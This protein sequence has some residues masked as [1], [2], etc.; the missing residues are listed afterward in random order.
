M[1][2]YGVLCKISCNLGISISSLF[3][4]PLLTTS[5]QTLNTETLHIPIRRLTSEF[6]FLVKETSHPYADRLPTARAFFCSSMD[7][8]RYSGLHLSTTYPPPPL[9]RYTKSP[10][11]GKCNRKICPKPLISALGSHFLL[12]HCTI[13]IHAPCSV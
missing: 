3:L 12:Y 11:P 5:N 8:R 6:P 10:K 13:P 7:K 4:H 2:P 9:P 1:D